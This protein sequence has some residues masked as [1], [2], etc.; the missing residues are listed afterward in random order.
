MTRNDRTRRAR[1]RSLLRPR[2][3]CDSR[4][5]PWVRRWSQT[6]RRL[7]AKQLKWVRLPPASLRTTGP[8]ASSRRAGR[9]QVLVRQTVR[10]TPS[11]PNVSRTR[12]AAT[13]DASSA[14]RIHWSWLPPPDHW[15]MIAAESSLGTASDKDSHMNRPLWITLAVVAT[16]G[17]QSGCQ[18]S[19]CGGGF[20]SSL[21][22]RR[23]TVI[24]DGPVLATPASSGP[25]GGCCEGGPMLGNPSI[26]QPGPGM[27]NGM[28]VPMVPAPPTATLP[29]P[30]PFPGTGP[31]P[32]APVP[33]S[34]NP[35]LATP[36]PAQPSL[37]RR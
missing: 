19:S 30:T 7:P 29:T 1:R 9:C 17:L 10:V 3:G 33:G 15:R 16:L 32:L 23:G 5:G 26:V 37:R 11:V 24:Y 22:S 21:T 34:T 25:Y 13:S 18:S 27:P 35:P 8:A 20:L 6:V 28:G 14:E 31:P 4:R 12:V 36:T 2:A